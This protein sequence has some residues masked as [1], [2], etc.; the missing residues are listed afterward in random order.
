MKK[1]FPVVTV[2]SGWMTSDGRTYTRQD[3][4]EAQ[5]AHLNVQSLCW[6]VT[7]EH[8]EIQPPNLMKHM[9]G[10]ADMYIEALQPF[11]KQAND[12][13]FNDGDDLTDDDYDF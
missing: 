12:A 11:A 1:H 13:P 6:L 3:E 8:G 4:A 2:I 7:D 9:I 5:Q 10:N